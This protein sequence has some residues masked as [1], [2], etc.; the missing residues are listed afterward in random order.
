LRDKLDKD[1]KAQLG[2]ILG[3]T[4]T[5]INKVATAPVLVT[6]D[7]YNYTLALVR[8]LTNA[9]EKALPEE[10]MGRLKAINKQADAKTGY[11]WNQPGVVCD[12]VDTFFQENKDQRRFQ[13]SKSIQGSLL[14]FS[15][16]WWYSGR[17]HPSWSS[18]TSDCSE[19]SR[20]QAIPN[21]LSAPT[22]GIITVSWVCP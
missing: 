15:K 2:S 4:A 22:Q 5:E 6:A 3:L 12:L 10:V 18:I 11:N 9:L 14:T 7:D 20:T 17:R 8:S 19:F 16:S 13:V 1:V 21:F